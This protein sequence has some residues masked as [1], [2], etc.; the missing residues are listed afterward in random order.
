MNCSFN[1]NSNTILT[2]SHYPHLTNAL[3]KNLTIP[4]GITVNKEIQ[5]QIT[6][7]KTLT[8]CNNEV[9]NNNLHDKLIELAEDRQNRKI[10]QTKKKSH[11]K[12]R[13]TKKK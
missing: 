13:K 3:F 2:D 6:N 4:Y 5:N 11:K 12:E 10:K 7:C 1:K 9:I 8:I